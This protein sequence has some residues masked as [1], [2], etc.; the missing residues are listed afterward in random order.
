MKLHNELLE[1]RKKENQISAEIL[2]KLQQMENSRSY[3]D[4]GYSSLFDYLVRGLNYSQSRAYERQSCLRLTKEIPELKEKIDQGKLSYTTLS[5]AF[6]TLKKKPTIEKKQILKSLENK[7]TREVKK[8]L[9]EPAK[10]IQI[11]RTVYQEK[12]H[13]RLELSHELNEKLERLKAL[14]SHQ[15]DLEMLFEKLIDQ[16]LKKYKSTDFKKTQSKNPRFTSRRLKNHKLQNAGYQCEYPGCEESH[17]LQL[18][19]IIPVRAGGKAE[20]ENLQ[21]LCGAH[22]RMKA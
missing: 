15:G 12:V 6:K 18:D 17:L 16:E 3:L 2:E 13:L 19:H 4:L 10:P 9:A 21:V 22:N 8:L 7:S 20:P 11:K 1:L 14:K 5:V